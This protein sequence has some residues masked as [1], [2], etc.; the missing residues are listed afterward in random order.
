[1]ADRLTNLAEKYR[2]DKCPKYGH[3]YT[4]Y[5]NY[6]FKGLTPRALLEVGIG[7][8]ETMSHI[9]NYKPGA[10]L[11][12]WR[13]YFPK[14]MI[15]GCDIDSRVLFAED[16]IKTFRC[17]ETITADLELV[18]RS[19]PEDL[20]IIID[21][22]THNT[23]YQTATAHQLLQSL[24]VGGIYIIEDVHEPWKILETFKDYSCDLKSFMG[25]SNINDKLIIIRK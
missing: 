1:M 5:Y 23:D 25:I 12:M 11:R 9:K 18:T 2:T 7:T 14:T 10:S 19:I 4:P 8:V 20:D 24:S 13:D 3:S 17:N 22:G 15:Y 21:D 6:L 16:R